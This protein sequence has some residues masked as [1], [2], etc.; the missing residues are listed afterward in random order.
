VTSHSGVIY[1]VF[2]EKASLAGR[3]DDARHTKQSVNSVMVVCGAQKAPK[4]A[5]CGSNVCDADRDIMPL[6][7]M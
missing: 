5:L 6:M 4:S 2:S 7:C 3:I 1:L